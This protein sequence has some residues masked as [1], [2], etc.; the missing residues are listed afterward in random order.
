MKNDLHKTFGEIF[1]NDIDAFRNQLLEIQEYQCDRRESE[2]W[3]ENLRFLDISKVPDLQT[4]RLKQERLYSQSEE[5]DPLFERIPPSYDVPITKRE[6]D[7][8][9]R[10]IAVSY[11]WPQARPKSVSS[12]MNPPVFRYQI[13]RP[14]KTSHKSGF[15]DHYMDRVVR[16]AQSVKITRLWV[17]IEC[18]YQRPEDKRTSPKDQELGVQVMDMVYGDSTHSVG[19]LTVEIQDQREIDMLSNL[20]SKSLFVDAEDEENLKLRPEVDVTAVQML[21]LHILSDPR[22]SRG[23]IFQEDHLASQKMV[24]LI[25]YNLRLD[26]SGQYKFGKIPGELQVR[27]KDFRQTVTMFCRACTTGEVRWPSTEILAKVTQYNIC[28]KII[29]N[30]DL[31]A[32]IQCVPRHCDVESSF[33]S[34][35]SKSST[36]S[37]YTKIYAYPTT[38]AS[39][40]DDISSR[41]LESES[42]RIA[43]LA[44]ALKFKKRLNTGEGSPLVESGT[45]SLSAALL[46]VILMNGEIFKNI[47]GVPVKWPLLDRSSEFPTEANILS[48]TLPSYLNAC[49]SLFTAPGRIRHQTF[50][51][52]CRFVSPIITRRG[53]ETKGYLFDLISDK[54]LDDEGNRSDL[55]LLTELDTVNWSPPERKTG[56]RKL[57][58]VACQ[59]LEILMD[60]LG[61]GKLVRHMRR[62]IQL[63]QH[64]PRPGEGYLSTSYVLDNMY[65]IYRA[66]VNKEELRLARLASAP[67]D[68]EPVALFISPGPY[69]GTSQSTGYLPHDEPIKVFASFDNGRNDYDKERLVSLKVEVCDD[70]GVTR[71]RDQR[72]RCLRN[73][74]WVNGIWAVHGEEM[75]TF[76]FPLPGITKEGGDEREV[77][78]NA[79]KKR[80][81]RH[82]D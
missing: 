44:N 78:S 28:N 70:I 65:A 26:K 54:Q 27:L 36:Q 58:D 33:G 12:T 2:K 76:V 40:L 24:L 62:H 4:E 31:T 15:P 3:A 77:K 49:Q 20:L 13:K 64:P 50:I 25:P 72:N 34:E 37:D 10:Y 7:N 80:K 71:A 1:N 53:I 46:T 51:D 22:W 74:G 81:R 66:L 79:G 39:V 42:D 60:K 59:V 73:L 21:I 45:Y 68:S 30:L 38:T 5:K 43:I 67:P 14:G 52:R 9:D 55:L 48:H 56:R 23:W 82:G 19:I 57:D 8:G 69:V 75:E 6:D 17:D 63:D 16:Y 11:K 32:T 29:H 61:D 47:P 41:W 18:I 35:A